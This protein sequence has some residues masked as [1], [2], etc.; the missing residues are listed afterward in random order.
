M[1]E[2]ILLFVPLFLINLFFIAIVLRLLAGYKDFRKLLLGSLITTFF[3]FFTALF[4][5]RIIPKFMNIIGMPALIGFFLTFFILEIILFFV[6]YFVLE[7]FFKIEKNKILS[8]LILTLTTSPVFL[9]L[10]FIYLLSISM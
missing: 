9:F 7:Y 5:F 6:Y 2:E 10:A 3:W 8:A 1:E 4:S